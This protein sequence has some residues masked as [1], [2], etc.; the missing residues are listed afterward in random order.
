LSA[1]GRHD[2]A[3]ASL[4]AAQRGAADRGQRLLRWRSHAALGR[5]YAARG[6]PADAR[7]QFRAAW[8]IVAGVAATLA[9]DQ[10]R[11]GFRAGAAA[12][13]PAEQ[14]RSGRRDAGLLTA[15]EREVVA[16]VAR[17]LSNRE[18]AAALSIGERTVETHVGNVLAKLEFGS[19]AQIAAWA[20][21]SGLGGAPA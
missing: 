11:E 6:R 12:L 1:L 5:L 10:L 2:D 4:R 21:A 7:A 17:G 18:I 13:L 8:E 16:L 14:A 19:R 15:R 9:D 3:E 20:S